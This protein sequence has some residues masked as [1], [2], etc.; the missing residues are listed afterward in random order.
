MKRSIITLLLFLMFFSLYS[1]KVKVTGTVTSSEDNSTIPGVTVLVK[2]LNDGTM[3]DIDG[4]YSIEVELGS[5]LAFSFIGMETHELVVS[6]EGIAN[7]VLKSTS[8]GLEELVVV[9]YGTQRKRDVTGSIVSI[10]GEDIKSSPSMNAISGLQG[11]VPGLSVV[12]VGG[13]GASPDVKIR[14]IGTLNSG[15][16]PL[17]V[18]DGIFMDDIGFLNTN[19]IKSLE[20]LKDASSLATFGVQGANGVIIITTNGAGTK[21]G[22]GLSYDG[23]FGVQSIAQRDRMELTNATEFT[24]LYNEYLKTSANDNGNI[25]QPWSGRLLGGGTNWVNEILR[26]ALITNHTVNITNNSSK[27]TSLVSFGYFKQDGVHKTDSY[28]RFNLRLKNDLQVRDWFKVG[29]NVILNSDF[30]DLYGNAF[31]AAKKAMPTYLP[32]DYGDSDFD[33]NFSFEGNPGEK[34][35]SPP[36][37]Q[38]TQVGNPLSI[39]E[40]QEG[41]GKEASYR[42]IA[43][44]YASLDFAKHFNYKVTGYADVRMGENSNYNPSYLVGGKT[45]IPRSNFNRNAFKRVTYQV[46]NMLSYKYTK[47]EHRING[48][49]GMTYRESTQSGFGAA[50]D[51][52][53]SVPNVAPSMWMLSS[54]APEY[55]SNGDYYNKEAF[56]SYLARVGYS[57]RDKY[58]ANLTLRADGSSKFGPDSRWGVFPAVGLAW[59]ASEEDFLD[60]PFLKFKASWGRIGNDKIGNYLY[61]PT[62]DPRGNTV[63]VDGQTIYIPTYNA[64]VDS[65]IHW[66]IV[67]GID[68]GVE[69]K[70]LNNNLSFELGYFNKTTKD[71]LAYVPAPATSTAPN[72]ITNAGSL[73]NS[74]LEFLTSYLFETGDVNWVVSANAAYLQNK[75]L[76]LGNDNAEIIAGDNIFRTVVGQPIGSMYG[77]KMM[78]IFQNQSEIDNAPTQ[79]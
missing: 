7:I 65:D 56:I 49:A 52:I 44:A 23:Y 75:I 38:A 13:A 68:A 51:S 59:V 34:Y 41:T 48:V 53:T 55:D 60:L 78:G 36:E 30:R 61:F 76:S 20:V 33:R 63:V 32:F 12:S 11:K 74:G 46:D 19:D 37:E 43:S 26:P 72:A 45:D 73:R 71:L 16:G 31:D 64:Y 24:D 77:Y 25:Y 22:I 27:S 39:L 10:S 14:G 5:V 66:E 6:K 8:L 3:T 50:R 69:M 21:E 4:L 17:Y 2:N 58:I 40:I 28:E 1:Q 35:S 15:T 62:I 18:V 9:G 67:E 57:F 79:D 70:F 47:D 29:S 54:G 42:L